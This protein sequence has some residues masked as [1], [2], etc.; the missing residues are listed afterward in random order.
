MHFIVNNKPPN[1]LA[2][3]AANTDVV[4]LLPDNWDDYSFKT[5]FFATLYAQK[6]YKNPVEMGLVKI[7]KKDQPE[8]SKTLDLLKKDNLLQFNQLPNSY[9]SIAQSEEY[10]TILSSYGGT[11]LY[12][13][14]IKAMNDI[15]GNP[16]IGH[17]F[18]RSY[19]PG[20]ETSLL[21]SSYAAAL[22]LPLSL[23]TKKDFSSSQNDQKFTA[24]IKLDGASKPH[25]LTFN[26]SQHRNLPNRICVLVGKNGVGKTQIL[27]RLG[28]LVSGGASSISLSKKLVEKNDQISHK[29]LFR[30]VIAISFSAFDDFEIPKRNDESKI[31][32]RY[33]GLRSENNNI[34][35]TGR[36]I[37]RVC[38]VMFEQ[39]YEKK[40]IF[41]KYL[42]Y[43]IPGTSF[44]NTSDTKQK[45]IRTIK[46]QTSAGQRI[47]I[48]TIAGLVSTLQDRSLLLFDEPETHLHPSMLTTMLAIING[49]LNEFNSYAIIS[50]HSPI[51]LQQIP[52]RYTQ[53]IKRIENIPFIENLPI[54]T[55]G[56]NLTEISQHVFDVS[57]YERDYKDIFLEMLR[58]NSNDPELILEDFDG[59]L[60]ISAQTLLYSLAMKRSS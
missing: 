28:F 54:E 58:E 52:A 6:D 46:K 21:R 34:L 38:N 20:L 48:A 12:L 4:H 51:V 19:N 3:K 41:D 49:L 50:T 45:I 32:Y 5:S 43:V 15:Y 36:L 1:L 40:Q 53:V 59:R 17:R 18:E 33:W 39:S 16:S 60:G 57:E 47:M 30:N 55:F 37:S 26:F 9:C 44:A 27:A 22:Y 56:E 29:G 14:Y 7:L 13:Q 2:L 23:K 42:K 24:K 10:Y 25:N 8:R 11:N 35:T 31:S